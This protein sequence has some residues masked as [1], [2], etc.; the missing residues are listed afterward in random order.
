MGDLVLLKLQSYKQGSLKPHRSHKLLPKYFG[1]YRVLDQIGK[2]AYKLELPAATSIHDVFLVSQLKKSPP[3]AAT[4]P[5]VPTVTF[6][7][8]T[9]GVP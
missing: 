5:R 7:L 8:L 1:P 6:A 4:N 3:T 9:R 2:T